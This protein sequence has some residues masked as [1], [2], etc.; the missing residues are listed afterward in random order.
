MLNTPLSVTKAANVAVT[1]NNGYEIWTIALS[2]PVIATE[3][4]DV[5]VTQATTATATGTLEVALTGSAVST[6]TV[7]SAIGQVFDQTADLLVGGTSIAFATLT[8]SCASA[9]TTAHAVGT[10]EVALSSI[11]MTWTMTLDNPLTATE[12]ANVPVTQDNGYIIWTFTLNTALTA[13]E[14]KGVTVTQNSATGTLEVALDGTGTT[15]VVVKSAIGQTFDTSANLVIGTGATFVAQGDLTVTSTT[16][17]HASGT[18]AIALTNS[19]VSTVIISSAAGQVFDNTTDL[20]IGSGG[21]GG[22]GGGGMRRLTTVASGG[23]SDATSTS[24]TAA[25]SVI[26]RSA[27]G[28]VFDQSADL[29]VGGTPI[30]AS[31]LSPGGA[32]NVT[33]PHAVGT[34]AVALSVINPPTVT[35]RTAIGQVFDQTA[36]VVIGSMTAAQGTLASVTSVTRDHTEVQGVGNRTN[37]ATPWPAW[38]QD[39]GDVVHDRTLMFFFIFF[40]FYCSLDVAGS[41]VTHYREPS[42][43][44]FFLFFLLSLSS[45]LLLQIFRSSLQSLLGHR[46]VECRKTF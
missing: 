10:L 43:T 28:Q 32:S 31:V 16:T 39:Y 29:V 22:G 44:L 36:D 40:F 11:V 33:T 17:P 41:M 19:A 35:V 18:L 3:A 20:V 21:G 7:R 1:Q 25:S 26:V 45:L 23:I 13:T 27:I 15:T 4:K 42:D 2:T 30:A 5:V 14:A 37:G 24:T 12:A 38:S 34:L 46:S 9:V 6:V 8:V